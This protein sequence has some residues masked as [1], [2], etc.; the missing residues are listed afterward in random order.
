MWVGLIQ[1]LGGLKNK[2]EVSAPRDCH[3]TKGHQ[4][5]AAIAGTLDPVEAMNTWMQTPAA[6]A[7]GGGGPRSVPGRA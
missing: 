6:T 7:L 2:A 5:D 4:G 1:V 3:S